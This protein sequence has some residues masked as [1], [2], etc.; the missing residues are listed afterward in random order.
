MKS[1]LSVKYKVL[2][3]TVGVLIC[4]REYYSVVTEHQLK[5][6]RSVIVSDFT[7]YIL[8]L[9]AL[10]IAEWCILALSAAARD[11]KDQ[12]NK[13]MEKNGKKNNDRI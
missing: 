8:P 2:I 10:F 12:E 9:T 11:I 4:L 13:H 6:F 1:N 3:R 5:M 7:M